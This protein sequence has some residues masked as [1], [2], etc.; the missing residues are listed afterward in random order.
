MIGLDDFEKVE[1]RVGTVVDVK[2]NKKSRNPAYSEPK[3]PP[4]KL[5]T[6]I[7]PKIFLAN[8]WFVAST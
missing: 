4:L 1:M 2:P 7:P 8:K 3:N 5:L 6:Y